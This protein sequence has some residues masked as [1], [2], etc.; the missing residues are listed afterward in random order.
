MKPQSVCAAVAIAALA[1]AG[2]TGCAESPNATA[3]KLYEDAYNQVADSVKLKNAGA[4][5]SAD[6]TAQVDALPS[7]ISDAFSKASGDVAV[8][9]RDSR[10]LAAGMVADPSNQ[11]TGVAFFMSAPDVAK[12]CSD[13]GAAITLDKS[14]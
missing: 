9:I 7:R 12:A 1:I 2:L 5:T 13:A 6:V 11:D 10:S 14:K 4:L 3:C 8:K